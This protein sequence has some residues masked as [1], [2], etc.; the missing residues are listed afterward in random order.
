MLKGLTGQR[1]LP[2]WPP[3]ADRPSDLSVV[4]PAYRAAATIGRALASISLQTP[5]PKRVVVVD[6]GS[7]DGTAEAARAWAQALAPAELLV[8]EQANRGAGAARNRGLAETDTALVAFLDAD[9]EWLPGKLTRSL[10]VL[11][12]EDYVLVAHNYLVD[13][14]LID[15]QARL[16]VAGDA[17]A[18]LYRRGFIATSTV[19]A[20]RDALV[21]AGGFDETLP[22]GQDFDL[23]LKVLARPGARFTVFGDGLMR[24]HPAPAGITAQTE[25]RLASVLRIA[26]RHRSSLRA[27]GLAVWPNL[28]FRV[29]A[30]HYEAFNGHRAA[31]RWGRALAVWFRFPLRLLGPD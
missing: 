12:E 11:A 7:G 25:Q 27:R 9:D 2:N 6:D 20:R 22:A 31:R 17:F 30:V 5:G 10:A 14:S 28:W 24:Y 4:I 18:G 3:M 21:A 16:R 8:I 15:C 13:E 29:L 1:R 23:W 19:V 26:H